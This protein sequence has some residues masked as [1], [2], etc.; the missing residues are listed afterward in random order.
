[1]FYG[2]ILVQA[3]ACGACGAGWGLRRPAP[4][5]PTLSWGP[6]YR[7]AG[8]GVEIMPAMPP[9]TRLILIEVVESRLEAMPFGVRPS[10]NFDVIATPYVFSGCHRLYC[11]DEL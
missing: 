6:V 2:L 3:E 10:R 1:L 5:P 8:C 11:A 4:P 9:L 7:V